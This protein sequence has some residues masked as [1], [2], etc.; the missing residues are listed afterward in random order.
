MEDLLD[1][2][3]YKTTYKAI[4]LMLAEKGSR[5]AG[6]GDPQRNAVGQVKAASC[7]TRTAFATC[8]ACLLPK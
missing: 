2:T 6:G 8:R 7:I 1:Y 3:P 4:E 5:P